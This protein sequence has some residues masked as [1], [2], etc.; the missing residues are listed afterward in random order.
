[1]HI[2]HL[3]TV[4]DSWVDIGFYRWLFYC[5]VFCREIQAKTVPQETQESQE[6]L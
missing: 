2:T 1:M 6:K 4:L 3:A 5:I